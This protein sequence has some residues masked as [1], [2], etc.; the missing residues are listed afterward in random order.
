MF[1]VSENIAGNNL[2]KDDL[3]ED[4]LP[5]PDSEL[6]HDVPCTKLSETNNSVPVDVDSN[7][8]GSV[9]SQDVLTDLPLPCSEIRE[10]LDTS[11]TSA[12]IPKGECF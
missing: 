11:C 6:A 4:V 8:N 3:P 12:N 2:E 5:L 10:L 7:N 9:L 1:G